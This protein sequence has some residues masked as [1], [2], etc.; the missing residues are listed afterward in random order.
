MEIDGEIQVDAAL[1]P[2]TAETK[3]VSGPVAGR[4]NVLV[5]PDLNSGNIAFKLVQL[6]AGANAF[7]QIL[8]GLSKPA[9]EI[10]RGSS[11]HDV[12]GAAAVVGCQ[13]IDRRL[14]YGTP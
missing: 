8:T 12:F 1:D 7:G 2:L 5:F 13:A 10:S 11:A 14:L 6:L 4:A 3:K 9:A